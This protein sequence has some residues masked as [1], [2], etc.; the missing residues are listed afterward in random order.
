LQHKTE[1]KDDCHVQASLKSI[2]ILLGCLDSCGLD[3]VL[4][5]ITENFRNQASASR[6]WQE[7]QCSAGL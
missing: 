6:G 7:T 5:E 2:A 1:T 4:V 3:S